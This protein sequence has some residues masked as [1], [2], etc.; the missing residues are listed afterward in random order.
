MKYPYFILLLIFT[1]TGCNYTQE[2]RSEFYKACLSEHIVSAKSIVD[3]MRVSCACEQW[4]LRKDIRPKNEE[5]TF[6]QYE[7]K[8]SY[9]TNEPY[10]CRPAQIL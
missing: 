10:E 5:I 6:E 3:K 9:N 8:V 7:E 2:E 4:S 1:L